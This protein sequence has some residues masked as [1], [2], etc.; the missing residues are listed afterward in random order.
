[1]PNS[2]LVLA[3]LGLLILGGL[4]LWGLGLPGAQAAPEETPDAAPKK[5]AEEAAEEVP[6]ELGA[7]S[8]HRD[9]DAAVPVARE[10]RQALLLLFQEVPG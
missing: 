3:G 4:A 9:F 6:V 10:R 8:W 2:P 7:V 5:A 1:M